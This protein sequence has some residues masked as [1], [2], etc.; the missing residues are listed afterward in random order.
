MPASACLRVAVAAAARAAAEVRTVSHKRAA[1][2]D[3]ADG[4]ATPGRAA[5]GDAQRHQH[6]LRGTRPDGRRLRQRSDLVVP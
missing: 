3:S 1:A 2:A 6:L 5:L 4:P